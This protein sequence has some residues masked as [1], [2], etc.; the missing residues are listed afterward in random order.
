MHVGGNMHRKFV[1]IMC[2]LAFHCHL[3]AQD[4]AKATQDSPREN[5]G[6]L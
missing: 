2:G 5:V 1:E 6:V 4:A 3:L